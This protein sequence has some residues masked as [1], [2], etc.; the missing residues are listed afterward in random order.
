MSD[1]SLRE[2]GHN[3]VGQLVPVRAQYEQDWEEI[4]RL[5]LPA[6]S[7]LLGSRPSTVDPVSGKIGITGASM[8]ERKRRSNTKSRDSHG[9]RAARTL[10]N[11]MHSGLSPSSSRN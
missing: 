7:D 6:R 11:G 1:L 9:A 4:S 2:Y 8:Q 10:T 3:L 5:A